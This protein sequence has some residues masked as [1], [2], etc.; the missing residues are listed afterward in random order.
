[1]LL[2]AGQGLSATHMLRKNCRVLQLLPGDW[3]DGQK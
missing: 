2:W 3:E 1:M